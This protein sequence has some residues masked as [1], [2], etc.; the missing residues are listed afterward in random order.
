MKQ[1]AEPF[2]HTYNTL[3]ERRRYQRF[4]LHFFAEIQVLHGKEKGKTLT[5]YTQ[6]ICAGGAFFS[7]YRPLAEKSFVLVS[8]LFSK[9]LQPEYFVRIDG[10]VC[11]SEQGGMAIRFD[12]T[13]Q[14]LNSADPVIH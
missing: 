10:V 3:R 11:R 2:R 8:F 5:L 13:Y 9:A 14:L 4:W 7:T 6:N 1:I 12:G